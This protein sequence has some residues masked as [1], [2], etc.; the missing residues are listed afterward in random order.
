MKDDCQIKSRIDEEEEKERREKFDLIKFNH[1]KIRVV[2]NGFAFFF[3]SHMTM[4][5]KDIG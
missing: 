1:R 5:T 2:K 4:I 3:Y